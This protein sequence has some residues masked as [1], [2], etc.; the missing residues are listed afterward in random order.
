MNQIAED[1]NCNSENYLSN[2]EAMLSFIKVWRDAEFVM[3]EA[4]ERVRGKFEKQGKLLPRERLS[5]LLDSG[6]PFLELSSLAGWMM[7]DDKDGSGAGGGIICGI[8]YVSGVRCMVKASNAAIKGGTVSPAGLKKSL[9]AQ[10]I[11]LEQKLPIVYLVES[12]GANL[13]YQSEIFIEGGRG[14]AN[15]A[16]LSAAGIPQITVVHGPSTAGGAYMPGLS[17]YVVMVR[18]QARVYLAGPP[19]LK[20]ATGEIASDEELGGAEM[21]ASIAGT[22]EFLADNDREAVLKARE[23]VD[24]L[25]WAPIP[26]KEGRDTTRLTEDILGM[27]S[28]DFKKPYDVQLL[29]PFIV[30]EGT[31][32]AFKADYDPYTICGRA[33]IGGHTVGLLGNNGP[34]TAKGATKATQFIQG[35]CQSGTPL[36]FLQ[37]TTGYMV[38]K[39]AEQSG[40]VKHG[41][42]MIQAVANATVPKVTIVVGGS[43]GAGNYGMCGRGLSPSFIFSW[44]NVKVGVMGAEQAAG[45]MEMI[46]RAKMARK[47]APIDEAM[48][49]GMRK[50]ILERMEGESS[51]LFGSARLWDDGV[52]D[53]RDTRSVLRFCLDIC[54]ESSQRI[55][56]P[57]SFGVARP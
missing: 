46:T 27:A 52:I 21:H 2:K 34:I 14:F 37:N 26:G 20:A 4:E 16:R 13:A 35:C 12:G 29:M 32:S 57:I 33:R 5:L 22:A 6:S 25:G 54:A 9:R 43:F 36:V 49:K 48:L 11:A 51:V 17:D 1:V 47:G 41:S 53:P 50:Q 19:L 10:E 24:L 3:H 31:F 23:I 15:Q 44:P 18:Q 45:V 28:A 56:N 42:K 55:L 38:G 30:D 39:D 40:I 8:G 7:H